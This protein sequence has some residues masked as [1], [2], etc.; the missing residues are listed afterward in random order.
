MSPLLRLFSAVFFGGAA[1]AWALKVCFVQARGAFLFS[2]IHT[3]NTNTTHTQHT[4]NAADNGTILN[5][6]GQRLKA[7]LILLATGS[8]ILHL[9]YIKS[10]TWWGLILGA[11]A[12]GATL[13]V[14]LVTLGIGDSHL[15]SPANIVGVWMV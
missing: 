12:M 3:H 9:V 6:E 13:L 10:L 1:I 14:P 7:S 2:H 4:Q 8:I 5:S 15:L 11:L